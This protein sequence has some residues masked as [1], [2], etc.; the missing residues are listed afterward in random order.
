MT[1]FISA[2]QL[3]P[4]LRQ[5]GRL[6]VGWLHPGRLKATP[7][8]LSQCW[9]PCAGDGGLSATPALGNPCSVC[10]SSRLEKRRWAV[11][12]GE[13]REPPGSG[14]RYRDTAGELKAE[15]LQ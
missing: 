14:P 6:T 2:L 1:C 8:F 13:V 7:T 9:A 10:R 3:L 12:E 4:I 11:P 15:R 5:Y